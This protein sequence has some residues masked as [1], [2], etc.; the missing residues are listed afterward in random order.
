MESAAGEGRRRTPVRAAL[1][2]AAIL[3]PAARRRGLAAASILGDWPTIVGPELAARCT[4]LAL[5]FPRGDR[6]AG[7]LELAARAS[8]A[9]EL[10]YATP[11]LVER[12]NA[13]LGWRAVARIHL[14]QRVPASPT[15]AE[16]AASE[17]ID[18]GVPVA[19]ESDLGR[20]ADGELRAALARLGR[21]LLVS[22]AKAPRGRP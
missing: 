11:Q 14:R 15:T 2:V 8:T 22:R 6:S 20:L 7:V 9:L 17:P 4:P 12:I 19:I 21:H 10:Q 3:P 13:H 1:L 18:T 5:R 16:A